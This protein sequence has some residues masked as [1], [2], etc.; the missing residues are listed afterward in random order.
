MTVQ[1][2]FSGE[3]DIQ[4]MIALSRLASSEDLHVTDLPY[5]LSSWAMDRPDNVGLWTDAE[6]RLLAWAVM[7]TPFWAIDYACHPHAESSLHRNI[8]AWADRRAHA[9]LDTLY[10][11]PAWFVNVFAHQTEWISD[12]E[13]AGFASQAD[14][15]N[16]SWSKVL[17]LRPKGASLPATARPEGFTIRPLAG[18]A[19][20]EAYV[21][22]HRA[23]F[24]SENMTVAWR[25][26]TLRQPGYRPDL[27]LVAVAPDGRLAAFCVCWLD[28]DSGAPA[29]GQ[30]EPLGV[31]AD[32]R[33]PGLGRAILTE[34]LRRL[35]LHG[36]G[37]VYVETDL[38]RNAASA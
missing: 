32:F 27:D 30:I 9:L 5:R 22:L 16:D 3:D 1:R 36:A 37:A 35:Y 19:E 21:A 13:A 20:V 17:M 23:I 8:L 33:N 26:H 2:E 6:G 29:R 38:D 28:P 7:Q 18:E 34:G 25:T 31:G 12:L 24:G 11:R 4:A 10:G 15:R 14:V